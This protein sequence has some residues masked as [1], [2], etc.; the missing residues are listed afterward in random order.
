MP[1]CDN[2]APFMDD[3]VLSCENE[4]GGGYECETVCTIEAAIAEVEVKS[5]GN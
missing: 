2:C 4:G 5:E 1:P 3:S